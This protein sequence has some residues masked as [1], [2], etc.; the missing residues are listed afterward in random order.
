MSTD[1]QIIFKLLLKTAITDEVKVVGN[2]K[3]LGEWNPS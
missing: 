1:C 2:I 3:E